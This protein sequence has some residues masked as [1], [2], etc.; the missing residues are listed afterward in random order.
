MGD[1]DSRMP[2]WPGQLFLKLYF[3]LRFFLFESSFFFPPPL[4]FQRQYLL[5]FEVIS[6][7]S[8]LLLLPP[9]FSSK[10]ILLSTSFAHLILSC[11][12]LQEDAKWYTWSWELSENVYRSWV[13]RMDSH[14]TWQV[15]RVASRAMG[16]IGIFWL[17]LG[18]K[19]YISHWYWPSKTSTDVD[20]AKHLL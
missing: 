15:N 5:P 10:S 14:I 4:D 19:W 3:S 20:L 17:K 8:G 12:L 11:S 13:L 6:L 2:H 9:S 7:L 18:P 1:F 16:S